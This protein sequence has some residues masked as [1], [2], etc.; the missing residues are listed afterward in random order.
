MKDDL[1]IG[2]YASVNHDEA[3]FIFGGTHNWK[4]IARLD[5]ATGSWSLV[6]TLNT[7]RD[8][9]GAVFDGKYFIIIG[10]YASFKTEN[11]ILQGNA[12]KCTQHES[13][14]RHYRFE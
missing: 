6:G 1:Y 5:V 14:L 13:S 2:Q 10:G 3:F 4:N 12:M 8:G 11:C 7:G 9:H